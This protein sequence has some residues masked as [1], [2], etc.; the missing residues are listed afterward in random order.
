MTVPIDPTRRLLARRRSGDERRP[1][2]ARSWLRTS[3]PFFGTATACWV[4]GPMRK[5]LAPRHVGPGLA[6]AQYLRRFRARLAAGCIASR[7][8]SVS[9]RCAR[10]GRAS[11]RPVSAH[12]WARREHFCSGRRTPSSAGSNRCR[13]SRSGPHEDPIE[14]IVRRESISLAFV[15][16]LQRLAPRQRA[17]LL[18]HDVLGFHSPARGCR[19]ARHQPG[20]RQ[21][22]P[23]PGARGGSTAQDDWA[24]PPP[25]TPTRG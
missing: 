18:L 25:T 16:A 5:R 9:T 13:T 1:S 4:P 6:A 21:Q 14:A 8:T 20:W 7:R 17:C 10:S 23:V 24:R 15:A 19:G 2:A 12:R 3:D 11:S 22:P